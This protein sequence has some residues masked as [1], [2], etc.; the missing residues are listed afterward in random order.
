MIST[1]QKKEIIKVLKPFNPSRIGVFGSY[2]RGDNKPTSDLDILASFPKSPNLLELIQLENELTKIL[3]IK[4]DLVT[5]KSLH[6][7]IRPYIE[8]DLQLIYG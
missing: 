2:A 5:E 7:K 6:Q 4:I 8:S 3:G 1:P